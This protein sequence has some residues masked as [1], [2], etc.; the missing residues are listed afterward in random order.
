MPLKR[1]SLKIQKAWSI[2]NQFQ[3]SNLKSQILLFMAKSLGKYERIKERSMKKII[4]VAIVA[5]TVAACGGAGQREHQMQD[6]T[7]EAPTASPQTNTTMYDT[8]TSGVQ[9][10]STTIGYDTGAVRKN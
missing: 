9:D 1:R 3:I 4:G 2:N 8:S 7:V 10:S 5:I 6:N